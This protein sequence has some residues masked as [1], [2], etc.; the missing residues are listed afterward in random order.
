MLT[1]EEEKAAFLAHFGVKGMKWGV[2]KSIPAEGQKSKHRVRLEAGYISKGA[3]KEVAEQKAD[4]RIKTEKTLLVAGAVAA[5]AAIAYTAKVEIGKRFVGVEL[6]KGATLKYINALGDKND[7]DRRLYATFKEG[8]TQKYRGLLA[9]AL[10]KNKEGTVIYET[11]LTTKDKI[12]APSQREAAKLFKEFASKKY[13]LETNYNKFNQGLV[14]DIPENKQFFDFLKS[15]GF[16]AILDS[17][18][19]FMSGYN[20]KKPII[21]FNAASSV[22]K[23]GEKVI[24]KTFSSKLATKQMIGVVAKQNAPILGLGVATVAGIKGMDA[25]AVTNN[26]YAAVN[27]FIEK[28]PGTKATYSE[29]FSKVNLDGSGQWVVSS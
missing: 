11:V 9:E 27:A 7:L 23:T 13:L 12:K 21:L 15:K 5:T 10:R 19:Q 3:S 26:K 25:S 8:D 2:R 14:L 29:L 4:R 6:E 17:N 16:N 1:Y 20:T 24:D 28:N 18:D 22:V